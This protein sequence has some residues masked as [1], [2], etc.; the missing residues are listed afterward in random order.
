MLYFLFIDYKNY[1]LKL[2][3]M[4]YR[5]FSPIP[6]SDKEKILKNTSITL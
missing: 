6:I 5:R 1:L 3:I 2:K 4:E